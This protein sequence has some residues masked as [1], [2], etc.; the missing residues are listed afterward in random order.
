MYQ[1]MP[2]EEQ[3]KMKEGQIRRI[4][5]EAVDGEYL[6][7]GVKASRKNLHIEIRWNSHSEMNI[8]MVLCRSDF[9]KG[10]TYDVL[11]ASDCKLV[12]EDMNKI[13]VCVLEYFKER[14]VSYYKKMQHVGYLRHL[15]LR[16]GRYDRRDPCQSCHNN[17]GRIRLIRTDRTAFTASA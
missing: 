5:D 16:R 12:H 3:M 13:L 1:T 17:A 8:K 14:K 7:E 4:M 10:S 9:I 15:L 11:T 6:F 2:Y